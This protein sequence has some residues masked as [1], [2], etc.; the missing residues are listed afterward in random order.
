MTTKEKKVEKKTFFKRY[1]E[2]LDHYPFLINGVQSTIITACGVLTSQHLTG[3][4]AVDWQEVR[5]MALINF[6]FITPVLLVV[7]GFLNAKIRSNLVKLMIDQ[8][9]LS[10]PFTAAIIALRLFLLGT[11]PAEIP[12]IIKTVIVPAMTSAW[13]FWIP[14]RFFILNYVPDN[15]QL[16]VNAMGGF[17]WNVIFSMVLA[18]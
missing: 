18:S 1:N 10:P 9:L 8:F 11:D 14:T 17:V 5:V 3:A 2:L 15:L 7:F 12:G 16:L 4:K 6:A 13:M